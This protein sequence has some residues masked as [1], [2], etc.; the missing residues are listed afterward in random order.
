[1]H[2]TDVRFLGQNGHHILTAGLQ[3]V[4]AAGVTAALIALPQMAFAASFTKPA[5]FA[6][7]SSASDFMMIAGLAHA[8]SPSVPKAAPPTIYSIDPAS[9]T[10]GKRVTIV[11]SGFLKRNTVRFGQSSIPDVPIAWQAGIQCVQRKSACHPG[12]N[13]ALV[14]TIPRDA[15]AEPHEISVGNMNGVSNI[16]TIAVTR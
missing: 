3:L 6:S 8:Q 7:S 13:Q 10:A 15:T 1:M 12:I 2:L 14:I 9:N 4:R 5:V 11:G 16:V